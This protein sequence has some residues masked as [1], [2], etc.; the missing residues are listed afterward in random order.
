M[1]Q[2][3]A[4]RQSRQERAVSRAHQQVAGDWASGHAHATRLHARQFLFI[5]K[6]AMKMPLVRQ[7]S[8]FSAPGKLGGNPGG[9]F[10][11]SVNRA[12]RRR[13]WG[14][15]KL[16]LHRD[17]T[18]FFNS[19]LAADNFSILSSMVLASIRH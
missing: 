2:A 5:A 1:T 18:E 7:V 13:A 6:A 19:L 8:C 4:Q 9:K 12:L 14:W 17:L 16:G 11:R 3:N 10:D 15:G